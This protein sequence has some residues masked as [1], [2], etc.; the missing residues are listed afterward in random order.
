MYDKHDWGAVTMY[1]GSTNDNG[2]H[3]VRR[4]THTTK[5]EGNISSFVPRTMGKLSG[6]VTRY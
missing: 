6:K 5:G 3:Q 1:M 2:S 4:I